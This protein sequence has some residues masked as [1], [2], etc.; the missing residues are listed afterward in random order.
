M[1]YHKSIFK[2]SLITG[3]SQV[4]I[5]FINLCK[6]KIFAI[7]IGPGGTGLIGLYSTTIDLIN[8]VY[9][10]GVSSSAVKEIAL[11]NK[12]KNK[13]LLKQILF[14]YRVIILITG[15][16]GSL[17]L[18]IFSDFF[19]MK[20]FNNTEHSVEFKILSVIV[21][22][23][24]LTSGQYGL[25]QGLRKIKELAFSKTIGAFVGAII[26]V[27]IIVV[28]KR[29][30]V[31][32]LLVIG[33]VA[34]FFVSW[35]F[36][37]KMGIISKKVNFRD[38]KQIAFKL[39]KIGFAFLISSLTVTFTAYY[40]RVFISHNFS[41][42]ELGIYTACWTLSA[43]YINFIL[44]AMGADFYPRLTE[45]ID[46]R[47]SAIELINQQVEAGLLMSIIGTV[48]GVALP[49]FLLNIF[50]STEFVFGAT[51]LQWMTLGMAI[52]IIVW[53][54]GFVIVTKSKMKLFMAFEISWGIIYL[55]LLR[56]F[57]LKW[58]YEGVGIAF[59]ITYVI[60]GIL[61]WFSA[62]ILINFQWSEKVIKKLIIFFGL[63]I[64]AMVSSR[65]LNGVTNLIIS[66]FEIL[67]TIIW[68]YFQLKTI[69][70][71]SPIEFF[72]HYFLKENE[73]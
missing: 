25:L 27:S 47:S 69:F 26:S 29:E 20:D 8:S 50:Y 34:T 24:S 73:K 44:G 7:F 14:V 60:Y 64:T 15:F 53:P 28:F 38:F 35:Y 51:L 54:L 52:K 56:L 58:G 37:N 17:T 40:S 30:G 16:L 49:W 31:I 43:F 2:T 46:N 9:N 11:A 13:N 71:K 63:L 23:V 32:P 55:V 39:I 59:F 18:F 33:S 22:V 3:G 65:I 19:S 72:K 12:N 67:F 42:N 61:V 57:T 4:I 41:I 62:I 45:I 6:A 70:S 5:M 10:L 68:I 21:F 36:T 1:S 48:T 66:S